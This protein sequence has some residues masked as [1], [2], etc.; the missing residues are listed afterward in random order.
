MTP[1]V[2]GALYAGD[3]LYVPVDY[4]KTFVLDPADGSLKKV[5]NTDGTWGAADVGNRVIA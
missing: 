1:T 5:L 4:G 3:M 2:L